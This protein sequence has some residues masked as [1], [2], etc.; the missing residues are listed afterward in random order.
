MEPEFRPAYLVY[1]DNHCAVTYC[2]HMEAVAYAFEQKALAFCRDAEDDC[3]YVIFEIFY[4][5]GDWGK[6][7]TIP[8]HAYDELQI[9]DFKDVKKI[10]VSYPDTFAYGNLVTFSWEYDKILVLQDK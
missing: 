10:S 7:D 6:I 4:E 8:A 2:R 1:E 9:I 3:K 5:N